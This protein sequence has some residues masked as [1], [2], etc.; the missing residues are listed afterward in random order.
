MLTLGRTLPGTRRDAVSYCED[1]LL[2]LDGLM[3]RVVRLF[4][5]SDLPELVGVA[6]HLVRV[7]TADF[8]HVA[9]HVSCGIDRGSKPATT[10]GVAD[11]AT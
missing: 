10:T 6:P 5:K 2:V 9:A 4:Q 11:E 1:C 8:V 7:E 3:A